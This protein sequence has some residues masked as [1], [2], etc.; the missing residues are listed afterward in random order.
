MKFNFTAHVLTCAIF[1][2]ACSEPAESPPIA[3]PPPP[4]TAPES[5]SAHFCFE[6]NQL[7]PLQGA[8]DTPT[9]SAMIP[10]SARDFVLAQFEEAP[11]AAR[12]INESSRVC[13]LAFGEDVIFAAETTPASPH[14]AGSWHG[15]ARHFGDV[16]VFGERERVE[17]GGEFLARVLF[18]EDVD[19]PLTVHIVN[20]VVADQLRPVLDEDLRAASQSARAA[21]QAE[22]ASRGS[23]ADFGDPQV[24]VR[25]V[26]RRL[27]GLLQWLP[28]VGGVLIEVRGQGG[29]IHVDAHIDV[30]AGS[31]LATFLAGAPTQESSFDRLPRGTALAYS[32]AGDGES[33]FTA[34]VEVAGERAGNEEVQALLALA[35]EMPAPFSVALG[36]SGESPW[37]D[38]QGAV[39]PDDDVRAILSGDYV[40]SLAGVLFDCPRPPRSWP[41]SEGDPRCRLPSLRVRESG[42]ALGDPPREVVGADPD[43]ARL[44]AGVPASLGGLYLDVLRLPAALSLF[45]SLEPRPLSE[46]R[47]API[48]GTLHYEAGGLHLRVRCAPGSIPNIVDV[49]LSLIL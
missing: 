45:N 9:L 36:T 14:A 3:P 17:E 6:T 12:T 21:A 29:A 35:E 40:R 43:I 26:E 18:V 44:A 39:P 30:N 11:A 1:L 16:A 34:L 24:F 23:E 33:V 28:D 7:R 49:A 15:D 37:L 32:R 4:P 41:A 42:A 10:S 2:S 19:A 20:G 5:M 22:Q 47:A 25:V 48:L 46:D 31:P 13:G 8:V 38:Y 27:R